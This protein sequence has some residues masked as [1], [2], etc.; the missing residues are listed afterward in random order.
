MLYSS[1]DMSE[2]IAQIPSLIRELVVATQNPEYVDSRE[3][4]A[5]FSEVIQGMDMAPQRRAQFARLLDTAQSQR[6]VT[7][8]LLA[9]LNT[10]FDTIQNA[11]EMD[12]AENNKIIQDLVAW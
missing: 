1:T 2:S 12:R 3:A 7:T 6:D 10:R 8:P 9:Q 5:Q 11:I 4:L